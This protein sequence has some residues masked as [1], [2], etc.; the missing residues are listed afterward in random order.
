MNYD[1]P[2]M[3]NHQPVMNYDQPVMNY[4]QPVMINDQSAGVEEAVLH[5]S[6][7]IFKCGCQLLEC[8]ENRVAYIG[9][10]GRNASI[11]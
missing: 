1:Q 10:L 4:E 5:W 3:N 11:V 2:M 8:V 6:G 7:K 9:N